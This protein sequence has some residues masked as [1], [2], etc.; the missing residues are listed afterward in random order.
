M[1][2]ESISIMSRYF[3]R[4]VKYRIINPGDFYAIRIERSIVQLQGHMSSD[5][6]KKYLFKKFEL[7]I[8]DQ[9]FIEGRRH[10][11]RLVFT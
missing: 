1:K 2:E 6:L 8:S 9:A 11:I 10:S 7:R 5:V 3:T 4:L